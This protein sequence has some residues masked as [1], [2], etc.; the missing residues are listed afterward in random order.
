MDC[1]SAQILFAR[2]AASPTAALV[3]T[4]IS[5][6]SKATFIAGRRSYQSHLHNDQNKNARPQGKVFCAQSE[7]RP[8]VHRHRHPLMPWQRRLCGGPTNFRQ[9]PRSILRLKKAMKACSSL[10]KNCARFFLQSPV[11]LISR[12]TIQCWSTSGLSQ[13]TQSSHQR[14]RFQIPA[15]AT[16]ARRQ[17][18]LRRKSVPIPMP[19]SPTS[20]QRTKRL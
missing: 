20:P 17:T 16:S 18:K 1:P 3:S 14:F 4:K 8:A 5:K 19:C 12:T 7:F 9:P 10:A 13:N 15:V 2:I 6:C 11:N